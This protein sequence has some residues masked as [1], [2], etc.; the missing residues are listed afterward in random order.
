MGCGCGSPRHKAREDARNNITVVTRVKQSI[1]KA[2]ENTQ[3]E[4]PTH[5]VKIINKKVIR[6]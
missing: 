1:K 3:A 5:I 4:K 2:W 6:K